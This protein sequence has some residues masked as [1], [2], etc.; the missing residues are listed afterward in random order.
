MN[1]NLQKIMTL[2]KSNDVTFRDQGCELLLALDTSE[3]Q[4]FFDGVALNEVG[5]ITGGD[6][7]PWSSSLL[8]AFLSLHPRKDEIVSLDIS[9]L[10]E[11]SFDTVWNDLSLPVAPNLRH[12][13]IGRQRVPYG[14]TACWPKN[15][16]LLK[17]HSWNHNDSDDEEYMWGGFTG[18]KPNLF[19]LLKTHPQLILH[20]YENTE[21]VAWIEQYQSGYEP[22]IY[23]IIEPS[24]AEGGLQSFKTYYFVEGPTM[25]W[26]EILYG[27]D[28]TIIM[29]ERGDDCYS[30][31]EPTTNKRT[32][33]GE[34]WQD[35]Y[36]ERES[37]DPSEMLD[38]P[39]DMSMPDNPL[40]SGFVDQA[41]W[42]CGG[43][44]YFYTTPRS[45]FYHAT[46][47]DPQFWLASMGTPVPNTNV[48]FDLH[49]NW[50][51]SLQTHHVPT[52]WKMPTFIDGEFNNFT[53]F[54][55][56][57][58]FLP[59]AI[60]GFDDA[61]RDAW[62]LI[63]GGDVQELTSEKEKHAATVYDQCWNNTID[64]SVHQSTLEDAIEAYFAQTGLLLDGVSLVET[65]Q[66]LRVRVDARGVASLFEYDPLIRR[67]SHWS[68]ES[69]C[70]YLFIWTVFDHTHNLFR[71]YNR[72]LFQPDGG[73]LNL[74]K[75]EHQ[76]AFDTAWDLRQ[77]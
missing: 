69:E 68:E 77:P 73:N 49:R 22:L 44:G 24:Y 40:F 53:F 21:V 62:I 57:K 52:Q 70:A 50:T 76:T 23:L 17:C 29:Y 72:L 7:L 30:E 48:G 45:Q 13:S 71:N 55:D 59:Q 35:E 66:G 12:L 3:Q 46:D 25:G 16:S 28:G 14:E 18:E 65:K 67:G 33:D 47:R 34:S 37:F 2:M 4:A 63:Q 74:T 54:G 75:D 39:T 32:F 60:L 31:D 36:Y 6:H 58:E 51:K 27:E 1:D 26:A 38:V 61:A 8:N 41:I 10:V 56:P 5:Q 19:Q 11:R 9:Q 42:P 64:Y 43:K 20:W 15:L